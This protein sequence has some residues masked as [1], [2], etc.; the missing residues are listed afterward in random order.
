MSAL[1]L[2]DR[3][4]AVR[5][6]TAAQFVSRRK[7]LG[8]NFIH[9]RKRRK[10]AGHKPDCGKSR[11]LSSANYLVIH[12]NFEASRS[13]SLLRFRGRSSIRL[14]DKQPQGSRS[15]ERRKPSGGRRLSRREGPSGPDRRRNGQAASVVEVGSRGAFGRAGSRKAD[16]RER[17]TAGRAR[18]GEPA[19]RA[20]GPGPLREAP[21]GKPAEKVSGALRSQ[22]GTSASKHLAPSL[23]LGLA[24]RFGVWSF[25]PGTGRASPYRSPRCPRCR[26]SAVCHFESI[27][28][29]AAAGKHFPPNA[30]PS[31]ECKREKFACRSAGFL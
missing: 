23:R 7:F 12:R 1:G 13:F 3:L 9:R 6:R 22:A 18:K 11:R 27:G 10:S 31:P 2:H 30:P 24:L 16:L 17:G 21:R 5:R 28:H 19:V 26:Y 8:D 4:A 15:R 14:R 25:R 29:A 20:F